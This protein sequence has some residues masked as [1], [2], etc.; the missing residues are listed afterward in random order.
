M[1]NL[2]RLIS[3]TINIL[4]ISFNYIEKI[5]NKFFREN[6][7]KT[8]NKKALLNLEII[9]KFVLAILNRVKSKYQMSLKSIR[10]HLSNNFEEFLPELFCYLMLN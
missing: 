5:P 6:F 1:I 7:C 2:F 4:S 10:K 8:T 3:F 9:H